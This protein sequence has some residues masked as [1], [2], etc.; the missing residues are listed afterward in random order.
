[1]RTG[2]LVVVVDVR[3]LAHASYSCLVIFVFPSLS[4][5]SSW[6]RLGRGWPRLLVMAEP[7]NGFGNGGS[8]EFG[9]AVSVR[10]A[11]SGPH[12]DGSLSR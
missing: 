1:M 9:E 4:V 7:D 5:S 2:V 12:P 11:F 3:V 10:R 6:F 8:Y